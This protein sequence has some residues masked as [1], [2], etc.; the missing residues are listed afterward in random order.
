M[1]A[2]EITRFVNAPAD[3]GPPLYAGAVSFGGLVITTQ[4]PDRADGS[5]ERGDMLRQCEKLF[6]NLSEQLEAAGSSIARLL[7]LTIYLT[8]MGDRAVFNEVY[9]ERV[10]QPVPVRCA[11]EVSALAIDGMKV[12]VT[13][14]AAVL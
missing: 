6:L 12:E 4:I 11:V 9:V 13:A 2:N 3:G 5:I 10:G 14:I 7:H 8:D 1:S